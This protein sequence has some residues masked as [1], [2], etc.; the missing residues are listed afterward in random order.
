MSAALALFAA[1]Y[2]APPPAVAPAADQAFVVSLPVA[3]AA[4]A[5]LNRH[6]WS[7][8][9]CEP[10]GET[11]PEVVAH[12]VVSAHPWEGDRT[13]WVVAIDGQDVDLA[14]VY[15]PLAGTGLAAN[16]ARLTDA[17]PV[18]GVSPTVTVEMGE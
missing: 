7:V 13:Q 15:V 2:L 8:R 9:L 14:Y 16:V 3:K 17:A 4:I 1:L 5:V 10:C 12:A 11:A 18:T 6:T